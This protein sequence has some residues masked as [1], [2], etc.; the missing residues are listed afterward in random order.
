MDRLSGA[1]VADESPSNVPA[2]PPVAIGSQTFTPNP[3]SQYIISSQTLAVEG[4]PIILSP[5]G[6]SAQSVALKSSNS[7]QVLVV[8]S[9]VQVLPTL[10]SPT[11]PAPSQIVV[12]GQSITANPQSQYIVSGQ[13]LRPGAAITLSASSGS[14]AQVVALQTGPLGS[15]LVLGSST[16]FPP[17]PSSSALGI[18]GLVA[19]GFGQPSGVKANSTAVVAFTGDACQ[20]RTVKAWVIIPAA[21][22]ALMIIL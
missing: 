12:N 2:L 17:R 11:A 4:A 16:S 9:S 5:N 8:G 20:L 6:G 3:A 1:V 22:A 15:I 7:R 19:G 18:G 14:S 21:L 10:A 13:T